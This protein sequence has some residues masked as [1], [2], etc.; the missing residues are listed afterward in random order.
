MCGGSYVVL[1]IPTAVDDPS[2]LYCVFFYRIENGVVFDLDA[3]IG[4]FSFA[5]RGIPL[6]GFR[7][8]TPSLDGFFYLAYQIVCGQGFCKR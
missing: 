4:T 8:V 2:Y 7:E 1:N 6:I 5:P 3:V